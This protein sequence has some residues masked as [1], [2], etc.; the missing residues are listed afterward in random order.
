MFNDNDHSSNLLDTNDRMNTYCHISAQKDFDDNVF[1]CAPIN[2][3]ENF[4][5][6][7]NCDID[8]LVADKKGREK[9]WITMMTL[10]ILG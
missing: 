10:K 7:K 8:E 1:V 9:I 2:H 5:F 3:T 4:F 6:H